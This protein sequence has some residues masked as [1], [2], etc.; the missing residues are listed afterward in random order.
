MARVKF[1]QSKV[2]GSLTV[3]EARAKAC[4]ETDDEEQ[5]SQTYKELMG[6]PVDMLWFGDLMRLWVHSPAK[7][8]EFWELV[9]ER[10]REEFES[11]YLGSQSFIPVQHLR[12]PWKVACY[13]GLRESF[14]SEWQPRGGIELGLIDFL[15]QA[16][17]GWQHF[18]SQLMLRS[19][20]ELRKSNEGYIQW[21]E[22]FNPEA[23]DNG[24]T[25]GH[26]DLPYVS[27]LNAIEH[28][29]R[30]ADRWHRIYVRTLRNLRDLRRF[31][32]TINNT[33]QINIA[34]GDAPQVNV[35]P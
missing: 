8:E 11:G 5:A 10:A 22:R 13:L 18:L 19:Q 15:V 1:F 3:E 26:W 29:S 27:E 9:K 21:Q 6:L 34:A 14:I 23:V 20:T 33:Q 28:A 24:Y 17:L 16:Y 4:S 30:M 32:V 12:K 31:S 7:G 25:K 35:A 2:G